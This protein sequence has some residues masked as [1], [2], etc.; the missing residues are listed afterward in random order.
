MHQPL[1]AGVPISAFVDDDGKTHFTAR[2]VDAGTI[3]KI[4]SKVLKGFSIGGKAIAKVGNKIT[5]LLLKDISVVDIPCNPES[6]FTVIKFDNEKTPMK[7]CKHCDETIEKCGGKCSGAMAEK[8]H[9]KKFDEMCA[10]V[11]SLAKTVE[12]ISKQ[13]PPD[14]SKLE[15]TIGDLQKKADDAVSASSLAEK[16]NIIEKLMIEG[17]VIF[18]DDGTGAKVEDLQKMDLP[19]L[20]F[21]ARNAQILPT[22]ARAIYSGGGDGPDEKDFTKVVD[23]KTVQL[24]GSELIHKAYAGLDLQKMI[25]TGTTANA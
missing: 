23:G 16:G 9:L 10:T 8:E 20:K 18:K 5:E 13:T 19:L 12:A 7:T 15:K 11:A 3:A 22:Q 1:A 21:A 17:R 14:I 6:Y 4:K 2:I 24:S 25:K